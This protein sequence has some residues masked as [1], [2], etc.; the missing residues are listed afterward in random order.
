M[1]S[2]R[3]W[4]QHLETPEDKLMQSLSDIDAFQTSLHEHAFLL[5]NSTL[6]FHSH[7]RVSEIEGVSPAR[8]SRSHPNRPFSAEAPVHVLALPPKGFERVRSVAAQPCGSSRRWET[9]STEK[10]GTPWPNN[11]STPNQGID[12]GNENMPVA[13]WPS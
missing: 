5:R 3:P 4:F 2:A 10:K 6:A 1:W 12:Q 9:S 7:E 8:F 13:L 11:R